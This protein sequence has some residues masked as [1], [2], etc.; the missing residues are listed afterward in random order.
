MKDL[1]QI[2]K[3]VERKGDSF[4]DL[5]PNQPQGGTARIDRIQP[6]PPTKPPTTSKDKG[7]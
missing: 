1:E 4:R 6:R 7:K 3:E 5:K 2:K